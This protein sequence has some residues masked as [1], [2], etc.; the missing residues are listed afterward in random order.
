M[1]YV[2]NGSH[3]KNDSHKMQ[4]YM[5][6]TKQLFGQINIFI[7]GPM[8]PGKCAKRWYNFGD[9]DFVFKVM[10]SLLAYSRST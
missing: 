4:S 5:S 1:T 3:F 10:R 6:I 2:N 7:F 9:L 8:K